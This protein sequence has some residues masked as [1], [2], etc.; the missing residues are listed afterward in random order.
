MPRR[1]FYLMLIILIVLPSSLPGPTPVEAQS[2]KNDVLFPALT[3]PYPVGRVAYNWIDESRDESFTL[4]TADKRELVVFVWY[5]AVPRFGVRPAP[6]IDSGWQEAVA[7]LFRFSSAD[8]SLIHSHAYADLPVSTTQATYPVLLMSPGLGS[9]VQ[10]YTEMAE[11]LASHGYIVVGISHPYSDA[12]TVFSDGRVVRG[13]EN[14]AFGVPD[15]A[16]HQETALV[17]VWAADTRFVV[18]RLESLNAEPGRFDGRLDLKKLGA[19]GHSLG[20]TTAVE[21]CNL[22]QRCLATADLDG[23]IF[24]SVLTVGLEQ[25][26]L[27]LRS[28]PVPES[29]AWTSARDENF[30]K[31]FDTSIKD[32]YLLLLRGARYWNFSDF[33]VLSPVLPWV[34]D[35]PVIGSIDPARGLKIT[36]D[37]LT[38]FFDTYVKGEKSPLMVEA[39]PDYPELD[40]QKLCGCRI[41]R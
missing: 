39:S 35:S 10:V 1:L 25:P 24:G 28:E 13:A 36:D 2:D 34:K 12:V 18:N 8:L 29:T 31:V 15:A 37:Y 23:M 30:Q 26:V 40:F 6:Y 7:G 20:G 32:A 19:L 11:Q 38:A 22:N 16:Q 4:D 21:F 17:N 5:P 41:R 9:L 14:T 27:M 3:G 33:P